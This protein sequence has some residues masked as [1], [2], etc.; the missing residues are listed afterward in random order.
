MVSV[1][2]MNTH[3]SA[4]PDEIPGNLS[5]WSVIRHIQLNEAPVSSQN[6]PLDSGN[7]SMDDKEP[8]R[9]LE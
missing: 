4:P 6:S 3:D 8:A 5:D 7:G 9:T 2:D 1:G